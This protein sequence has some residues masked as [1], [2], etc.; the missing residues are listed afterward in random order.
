MSKIVEIGNYKFL[1][2]IEYDEHN[3]ARRFYRCQHI[4]T[5]GYNEG[6]QCI[7]QVRADS[8]IITQ[9]KECMFIPIQFFQMKGMF[10]KMNI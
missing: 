4:C 9:K 3:K 8:T 2:F 6:K 7:F 10:K 1:S 5:A